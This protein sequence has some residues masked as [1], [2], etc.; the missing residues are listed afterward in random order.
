MTYLPPDPAATVGSPAGQSGRPDEIWLAVAVPAGQN[1]LTVLVRLILAIPHLV[2]LWVLGIAAEV[3]L[4]VGWFAALVLGRLP[5]GLAGFLA[6][7]LRWLARVQAYL[8]LLTDVYPPFELG[9][10]AYPAALLVRPGPLNRLAV[11]LRIVLAVPAYLVV[12]VLAF[13]SQTLVLF[14][15]WLIVLVAGRMPRPLHEAI[16]AALR[17][18]MRFYGY[19]FLLTATYPGGLFGDQPGYGG[20][21]Y[22]Q[23]GFGQPGSGQ[24]GY[25]QPGY[26]AAGYAAPGYPAAPPAPPYAGPGYGLAGQQPPAAGPAGYGPPAAPDGWLGGADQWRLV[27][28]GTARRLVAMFLALGVIVFAGYVVAVVVAVARGTGTANRAQT[29]LT[30]EADYAALSTSVSGFAAKVSACQGHLGC[31]T[32][33]DGQLSAAFG[34]FGTRLHGISMPDP[35]SSAA[36]ATLQA[37][38]TGAGH[39]LHALSGARSITQYQQLAAGT[40]LQTQL[41]KFDSDYAVLG[42]SLGV[43]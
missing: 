42:R 24:P 25:G 15:A 16:A 36:S 10:A 35:A 34:R 9:E 23:P 41:A 26:G 14:V 29:A 28:S 13:G 3:V 7:Y 31:V 27:L 4:V 8:L 18:L 32:R 6:G 19:T 5:D 40:G 37:D 30:V 38:A 21:G 17:Y 1:R 22:G 20:P 33:V 39:D 2:V 43:G 11:L 12:V